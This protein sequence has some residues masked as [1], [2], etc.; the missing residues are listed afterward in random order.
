ME[1]KEDVLSELHQD[2]PSLIANSLCEPLLIHGKTQKNDLMIKE[3]FN[4]SVFLGSPN[5]FSEWSAVV[6]LFLLP[7]LVQ[8]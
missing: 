4:I 7:S 6:V 8:F 2:F 5:L 1:K 3:S